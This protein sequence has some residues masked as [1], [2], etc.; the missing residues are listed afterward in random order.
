[1]AVRAWGALGEDTRVL[2]PNGPVPIQKLM[3]KA[4]VWTVEGDQ[5]KPSTV[6]ATSRVEPGEYLELT[7][8]G[9]KLRATPERPFQVEP[10]V[11]RAASKLRVGDSLFVR[12]RDVFFKRPIDSITTVKAVKPAYDLVV[13]GGT[14]LANGVVVHNKDATD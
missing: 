7:V 4:A 11:F 12:Q 1:M 5:L 10:G 13:L 2:A 9:C 14:F 8:L 6:K 3:P